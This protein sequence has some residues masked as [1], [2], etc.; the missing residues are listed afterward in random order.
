MCTPKCV[1]L[2]K[3]L[4]MNFLSSSKK[5]KVHI[6]VQYTLIVTDINETCVSTDCILSRVFTCCYKARCVVGAHV[7]YDLNRG[8][9]CNLHCLPQRL[10]SMFFEEKN[11]SGGCS[12]GTHSEEKHLFYS[13]M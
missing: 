1:C 9:N 13:L 11:S 4:M 6:I 3:S 10:K 7:H 2:G 8:K 12:K 5:K